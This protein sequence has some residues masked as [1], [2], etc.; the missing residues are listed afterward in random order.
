MDR[1][2]AVLNSYIQESRATIGEIHQDIAE[3]RQ[4][5]VQSQKQWG[6]ITQKLGTFV[7]DIVAP[8]IPRLGRETFYLLIPRSLARVNSTSCL[9]SG[10]GD[11][12][13]SMRVKALEMVSPSRNRI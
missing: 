1:L 12:S 6:E 3:M 10:N 2:E 8:N 4:W 7:E 13:A 5:R 9:I 11:S